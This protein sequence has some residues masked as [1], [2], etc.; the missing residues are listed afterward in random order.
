MTTNIIESI[1]IGA[2]AF[3]FW[4]LLF[5]LLKKD[6]EKKQFE[7]ECTDKTR[8]EIEELLFRHRYRCLEEEKYNNINEFIISYNFNIK[9]SLERLFQ[10]PLNDRML[11]N[12]NGDPEQLYLIHSERPRSW[13]MECLLYM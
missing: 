6:N 7:I 2:S 3:E 13:F 5:F 4:N 12:F 9:D 8:V 10:Q 1:N 11:S